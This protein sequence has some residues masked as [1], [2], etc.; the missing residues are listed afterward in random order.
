MDRNGLAWKLMIASAAALVA[1]QCRAQDGPVFPLAAF[2]VEGGPASPDAVFEEFAGLGARPLGALAGSPAASLER[3]PGISLARRGPGSLEPLLRGLGGDRVATAFNGLLLPAAS[4]TA[5]AAGINFFADLGLHELRVSRSLPSVTAGPA[6]SGG[7]IGIGPAAALQPGNRVWLDADSSAG[8]LGG[9]ASSV[10]PAGGGRLAFALGG[11][12]ADDYRTGG[13]ARVDADFR[14]WGVAAQG[15]HAIGDR[16]RLDWAGQYFRQDLSRN[17]SLPLDTV[18]SDMWLLTL[19]HAIETGD[20][21]WGWE[22]GYARTEARLS[23]ADR[24]IAPGAPV[25]L[26]EARSPARSARLA[27]RHARALGGATEWEAGLD[28]HY[29]TRDALRQRHLVS[30]AQFTDHIWPDVEESRPGAFLELRGGDRDGISWRAGGRLERARAKAGALDDPVVAVPGARGATIRENFIAFNGREAGGESRADWTGAANIVVEFPL[31]EG[32]RATFAGGWTRAAPGIAE[33]YRAFLNALG[34]GV[35][36]G[37]P[38]L[39]P[40]EKRELTAALEGRWQRFRFHGAAYVADF[41]DYAA[42]RVIENAPLVYGF[43]NIEARFHGWEASGQV[44]LLAG[45]E[46]FLY[47]T[48]SHARVSGR[49]RTAG[50]ALAEIPPWE[51]SAGLSLLVEREPG[52]LRLELQARVVGA[53]DNPAPDI[54]PVYRDT[55]GHT[56]IDV[57]IELPLR[58]SLKLVVRVENLA[59]RQA[60]AYLQPPVDSGAIGPSSGDLGRGDSIPLPGRAVKLRLEAAF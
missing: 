14:G 53:R 40:E 1:A 35:E 42:R 33:L 47:L 11:H 52:P 19:G 46:H 10:L 44:V 3:L 49:D 13:G 30:G 38:A 43:R 22:A 37:N 39:R 15:T 45:P 27:A 7:R 8:G 59:D 28:F 41:R 32:I 29:A 5:T 51:A 34:G 12:R 16:Q 24:V 9:G 60:Y 48:A 54:V 4:P 23:S 20:S 18:D 17:P 58:P 36:L 56:L 31:H 25:R 2:P 55:A 21:R 6:V 26:V 57:G 50:R